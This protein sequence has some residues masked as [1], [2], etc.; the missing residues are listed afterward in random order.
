MIQR[1]GD[2]VIT[3]QKKDRKLIS[4]IENRENND[5]HIVDQYRI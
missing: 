3:L 4:K 1:M 2:L 5:K